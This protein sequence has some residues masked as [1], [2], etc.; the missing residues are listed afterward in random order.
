MLSA[1]ELSTWSLQEQA[2]ADWVW[3]VSARPEQLPPKGDWSTWLVLAGR[4]WG[5]SRTGAAWVQRIADT[6]PHARIALV[7]ATAADARDV[8]VEG[9]SG[10]T[11]KAPPWNRPKYEPSKRRVT[12]PKTGAM[13]TLFSG[14]EPDRLRGPQH[15]FAWVDELAAF[16]HANE[17]WAMLMMGLRLGSQ[18]RAFV[19]TTPRPIPLI[20]KLV[21]DETTHVTRGST[22]DNKANLAPT[23]LSQ[24]LKQYEGT[25]LGRQEIQGVVLDDCPG[26]LWNYDQLDSLRVKD[27]P[28]MRR[29]VVAL[30]PAITITEESA[31]TG[32]VVCGLGEDGHG[33]VLSDVSGQFSPDG[34]A[35]KAANQYRTH[36]AD[37]VV[38][39]VNQGGDMVESTLRTVDSTIPFTPVRASRGKRTRAEPVAALFEQ[40]KC[41][42]VGSFPKLEDQLCTWD[43]S[44]GSK[45]PDRLDAMVWGLSVLMLGAGSVEYDSDYDSMVPS[46][47]AA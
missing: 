7:G 27:A 4:G 23:F 18:P 10:I 16:N 6:I 33:Y 26:A 3:E 39:E 36:K 29:I 37:R 2:A 32:I 11:A 5:K 47:R 15:H 41:H 46:F 20:R 31:E 12:W 44:D 28:S 22:Y 9:E 24:I 43:A 17:A 45:S 30:D 35:R 42:M 1:A 21:A 14:D 40:G 38:A 25:R 13:A 34:W 19:S 8:M